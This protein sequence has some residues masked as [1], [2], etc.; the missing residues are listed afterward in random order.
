M[1]S[2]Q[3]R[4]R[5]ERRLVEP[6]KMLGGRNKLNR[7]ANSHSIRL[8]YP[9]VSASPTTTAG[10]P[11]A[12][13]LAGMSLLTKARAPITAQSPMVTPNPTTLFG[14][15]YTPFPTTVARLCILGAVPRVVH[16]LTVWCVY[17]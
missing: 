16:H 12:F 14:P 13:D 3:R 6:A 2:R 4:L 7:R 9:E 17:I 10:H 1:A 11:Q 15:R 8:P 5:A